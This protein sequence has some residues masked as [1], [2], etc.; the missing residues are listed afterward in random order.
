MADLGARLKSAREEQGIA[1]R[2]IAARTKISV[3]ALEAL[4]RN[5][6]SRIPGG[7]FGRAFVR[8]YA[9]ESGLDPDATVG[10]FVAE[11]DESEREAAAR[12]ARAPEITADDRVFLDRQRR[13]LRTLQ[14]G[15]LAVG[16]ALLVAIVW[17][18]WLRQ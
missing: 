7:I 15:L 10:D 13:A 11:L 16:L 8:S 17:W 12:G 5:D 6:F 1:L 4:E 2:E 9:L 18:F 3:T 14:W